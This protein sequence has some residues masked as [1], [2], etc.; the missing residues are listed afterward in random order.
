VVEELEE[1]LSKEQGARSVDDRTRRTGL[2]RLVESRI[3]QYLHA[4][5]VGGLAPMRAVLGYTR[6]SN[7]PS[8]TTVPC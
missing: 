7:D 2:G 4:Y 1:V 6:S 3:P 5:H 8:R